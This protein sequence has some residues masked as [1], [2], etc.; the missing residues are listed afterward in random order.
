MNVDSR[1]HIAEEGEEK[2]GYDD[3]DDDDEM[4]IMIMMMIHV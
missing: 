3:V 2:E 4:M 1:L